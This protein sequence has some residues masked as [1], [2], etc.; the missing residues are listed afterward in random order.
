MTAY[1]NFGLLAPKKAPKSAG[2]EKNYYKSQQVQLA[3]MGRVGCQF[4][5]ITE[6]FLFLCFPYDLR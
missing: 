2:L 6:K 1:R 5:Q 3:H 4:M